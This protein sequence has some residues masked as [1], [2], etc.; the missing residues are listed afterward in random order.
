MYIAHTMFLH[1]FCILE[2]SLELHFDWMSESTTATPKE[3]PPV[4]FH[5]NI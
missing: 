2:T 5:G 1:T 3:M 4:Y